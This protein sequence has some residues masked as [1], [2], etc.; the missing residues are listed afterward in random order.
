MISRSVLFAL[1]VGLFCFPL[2]LSGCAV[3]DSMTPSSPGDGPRCSTSMASKTWDLGTGRG[4]DIV[5]LSSEFFNGLNKDIRYR[6][7]PPHVDGVVEV[8]STIIGGL[9]GFEF[10]TEE[11]AYRIRAFTTP[12]GIAVLLTPGQCIHFKAT[13]R[14]LGGHFSTEISTSE[15]IACLGPVSIGDQLLI[16]TNEDSKRELPLGKP[17]LVFTGKPPIT[18]AFDLYRAGDDQPIG[19]VDRAV[20]DSSKPL[21]E[22]VLELLRIGGLEKPAAQLYSNLTADQKS[23]SYDKQ[24]EKLRLAGAKLAAEHTQDPAELVDLIELHRMKVMPGDDAVFSL[25]AERI[26]AVLPKLADGEPSGKMLALGA[27]AADFA[28]KYLVE[29]P[30]LTAVENKYGPLLTTTLYNEVHAQQAFVML[31]PESKYLRPLAQK[32]GQEAE[33]QRAQQAK[34]A[35]ESDKESAWEDVQSRG[36]EITTLAYK[37]RFGRQNFVMSPH[38]V[39]GLEGMEKYRQ[40][41]VRDAFCPAKR[42][43][44]KT[45]GASEVQRRIA[46]HCQTE[47]PTDVGVGGV[48]KTLTDDCRAA[49][50]TGC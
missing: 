45:L 6:A 5:R 50:A 42:A 21:P 19:H 32:Q 38:N 46:D 44:I 39:R 25:I 7:L 30:D 14:C 16:K 48:E 11:P 18:V 4:T 33:Q 34:Q 36:D 3:L 47:A 43:A 23:G 17:L 26:A 15:K 2:F 37:I 28:R 27:L 35:E 9:E 29:F 20:D 8:G 41:L 10:R 13:D 1:F 22:E 12:V 31:F 49:F 40:G 24:V